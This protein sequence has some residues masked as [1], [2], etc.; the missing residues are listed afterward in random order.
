MEGDI[1]TP[2]FDIDAYALKLAKKDPI[3]IL[4]MVKKY[5]GRAQ[6]GQVEALRNLIPCYMALKKLKSQQ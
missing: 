2:K 4:G 6:D 1:T 3:T 5:A